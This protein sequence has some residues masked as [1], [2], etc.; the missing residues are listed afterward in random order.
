MNN[1]INWPLLAKYLSGECSDQEKAKVLAN[2]T[3]ERTRYKWLEDE[4]EDTYFEFRIQVD[5]IFLPCF[6]TFVK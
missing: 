2:R 1:Q 3:E 5:A 6:Q 4:E